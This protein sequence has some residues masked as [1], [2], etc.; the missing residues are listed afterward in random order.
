MSA[1]T[2]GLAITADGLEFFHGVFNELA[3]PGR[4]LS[5]IVKPS[6]GI[7]EVVTKQR[8]SQLASTLVTDAKD[9]YD[10]LSKETSSMPEQRALIFELA[11]FR[12]WLVKYST[13]IKWT[14]DENMIVDA[15]T[16]DKRQSRNHL[17]RILSHG[18]WSIS[19]Q[20]VLVRSIADRP[21]IR[22]SAN[23]GRR[24]RASD[25]TGA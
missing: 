16:K 11:G 8:I 24:I 18:R 7:T 5:D 13:G 25:L 14:A 1:E 23:V 6:W 15:L 21:L 17:A 19:K 9:L 20:D 22:K 4:S 3:R 12:E 10:T 2:R